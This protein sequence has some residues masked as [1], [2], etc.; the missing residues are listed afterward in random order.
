MVYKFVLT[1]QAALQVHSLDQKVGKRIVKKL[2]W[3]AEQEN[4]LRLAKPLREP[5]AGDV[6]FRIGEYRL[7]AVVHK[8]QKKITVVRVG[9]RRDVYR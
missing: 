3:F 7:V 5:A 1:K 8:K 4:P 9:H 6:R 2:V